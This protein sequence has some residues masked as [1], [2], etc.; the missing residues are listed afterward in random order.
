MSVGSARQ[1]QEVPQPSRYFH[2]LSPHN[3][4]AYLGLARA[5]VL[6]G[7]VRG[8]RDAAYDRFFMAWQTSEIPVL[9]EA[10]QDTRG[11]T[12][13]PAAPPQCIGDSERE[14]AVVPFSCI[15]FSFQNFRFWPTPAYKT[16]SEYLVKMLQYQDV[17]PS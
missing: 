15:F 14:S 9:R 1:F 6:R 16:T 2:G 4:L 7:D 10:R 17:A 12:N 13:D 3:R 11:S 8:A 5:S